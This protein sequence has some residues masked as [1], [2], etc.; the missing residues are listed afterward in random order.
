M[1]TKSGFFKSAWD[2]FRPTQQV[3]VANSAPASAPAAAAPAAAPAAP[4]PMDALAALWKND[5]TKT[6]PADPLAGPILNPDNAKIADAV[7]RI[8]PLAN[9][10]ANLVAKA[11]S[12]DGEALVALITQATQAGLATGAQIAAATTENGLQ[13][14]TQ[15]IVQALPDRIKQHAID[16]AVASNALLQHPGAQPYLE[17]TR[18]QI[19]NSN[20]HLSPV[21]INAQAEAA[22]VN[23]GKALTGTQDDGSYREGGLP[24][25]AQRGQRKDTDW[26]AWVRS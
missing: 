15:R 23:F 1:A 14:Q 18:R 26:D 3:V 5:P 13:R 20:P 21:E 2:M 24:A 8:D 11:K 7:K 17:M 9:I 12:G 10:D 25:S 19:A 16:T 22:L 4:E 6:A